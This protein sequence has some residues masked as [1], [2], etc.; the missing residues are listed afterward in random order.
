MRNARLKREDAFSQAMIIVSSAMD[1]V[2]SQA[3][4]QLVVDVTARVRDR[5][6]VFERRLLRVAE[7][8]ALRVVVERP[9]LLRRD[10][11]PA[12]HGSIDVLSELA[13]FTPSGARRCRRS[14]GSP[15]APAG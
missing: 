2:V 10:A 5:V 4:E 6:G 1:V 11:I 8:G 3:R 13:A 9:D 7:E 14:P 15:A 12:A